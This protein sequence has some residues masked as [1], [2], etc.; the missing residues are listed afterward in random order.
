MRV[1]EYRLI[2]AVYIFSRD[3]Y[4]LNIDVIIYYRDIFIFF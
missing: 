3:C 4:I 1:L 2:K